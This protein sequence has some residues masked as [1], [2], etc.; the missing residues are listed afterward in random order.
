M[1]ASS[2][3]KKLPKVNNHPVGENSPNLVTL[4]LGEIEGRGKDEI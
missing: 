4:T 1:L 3:I 2:M